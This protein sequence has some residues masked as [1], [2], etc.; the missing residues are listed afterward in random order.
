MLP[1][2]ALFLAPAWAALT[3]RPDRPGLRHDRVMLVVFGVLLAL[4]IGFRYQVGGDWGFE[5]KA[6][7]RAQFLS[8]WQAIETFDPGFG[9]LIW[10]ATNSGFDVWSLNLMCGA[11]FTTGLI[12]F[13][14]NEPHPWLAITVAI[15]Y[16]VIVVAM[17]YSRQSVAIGLIMM[18]LVALQRGSL[19]RFNIF[20][21][22][23]ATVH[24]TAV[25]TLPLGIV[26]TRVNKVL[27]AAIGAP[28]F[29]A[30]FVYL[31]QDDVDR[32]VSGY[33]EAGYQSQGAVIRVAMNAIPAIA[34]FL[35]RNRFPVTPDQKIVGTMLSAAA[36]AFVPLLILSP[37]STA[38]DRMALYL[39]PL[40]MFVL[41]RLP[42]ALAR[43]W[44]EYRVLTI[45]VVGYSALVLFVWLFFAAHSQYWLPYRTFTLDNLYGLTGR[46]E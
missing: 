35:F 17:G 42:L 20:T 26:A 33:I 43:S 14:R 27:A 12:V 22:L 8:L 44:R 37:S 1:Y 2:L 41:G 6:M 21:F 28:V 29:L 34:F 30:A 39:I 25:L 18:G 38:V 45:G 4:M 16:L 9:V 7:L 5:S 40:Q 24:T 23:A 19:V 15:P 36:L 13:C 10:F 46:G 3:T 11:I 32:Y 31:L